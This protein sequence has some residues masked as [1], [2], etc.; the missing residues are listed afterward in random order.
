VNVTTET[1]SHQT[2]HRDE[3]NSRETEVTG[4]PPFNPFNPL[5]W[6]FAMME[7]AEDEM[8]K[9][10]GMMIQDMKTGANEASYLAN[11]IL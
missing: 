5:S 7:M 10:F 11:S 9:L 1:F 4:V 3:S 6:M 2:N 8:Q